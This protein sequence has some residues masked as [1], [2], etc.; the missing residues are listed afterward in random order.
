M[1]KEPI[2]VITVRVP[3]SVHEY[4]RAEAHE[5]RT[6]MNKLCITKLL[7]PVGVAGVIE[8]GENVQLGCDRLKEKINNPTCNDP[9]SLVECETR[10][11]TQQPW[12]FEHDH[13]RDQL[14]SGNLA[15]ARETD[16]HPVHAGTDR[17]GDG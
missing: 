15:N 4:L 3:A 5:K 1:N 12:G 2:R 13:E 7:Q 16:Q 11:M 6:S 8:E 17:T 9:Q 14:S 10:P